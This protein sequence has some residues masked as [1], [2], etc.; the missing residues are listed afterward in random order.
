MLEVATER[1]YYLDSYLTEFEGEVLDISAD[2]RRVF[3]DRTA[4]YPASGGQPYDVGELG[5][6]QVLE[7][8]DDEDGRVAHV[9][10]GPLM[11]GRVTGKIDWT[12][13]YDHMQQHTGQHLLSAV[14]LDLFQFPTLSFH[15]GDQVSTIELGAKEISEQQLDGAETRANELARAARPVTV[16][17]E[18][19]GSVEGLRKQSQRT[20]T[21]RIIEIEG[22]DKS[23]CGGTHV[24]SLAET[25]PVL[26]RKIEKVR[27]NVRLEF[28]CGGRAIQRARQDFKVLQEL[29]RQTATALDK[30]P[31]WMAAMKE[32]LGEAEK[33]R[34]RLGAELAQREGREE[35]AATVPSQDGI[36]RVQWQVERIG[37]AERLKALAYV[38]GVRSV[39][40]IVGKQPAGVL[41]ACST[42]S[43]V[44]AGTILKK[45]LAEFGGR[46][47]GS[48][49]LAQGSAPDEAFIRALA[50]K[51]GLG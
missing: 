5:G 11:G 3:L 20:G 44:D 48:A 36:R 26:T 4:F 9:L 38:A 13:R 30:L 15:M 42:D 47:G 50:G 37:E 46:G 28:V 2:G 8:A 17:F 32:R 6:Q 49:T 43:A 51:L 40:L 22:V 23:A 14:L 25:L 21:L 29:A 34:Q 27:G 7:V 39:A 19:A 41:I 24:R 1:L 33:D 31:E 45:T 18:D 16:S 35:Y 10:A 12:R